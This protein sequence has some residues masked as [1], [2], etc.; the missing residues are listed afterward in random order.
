MNH[1]SM[2]GL[3]APRAQDQQPEAPKGQGPSFL[4][5]KGY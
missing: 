3:Q 5:A 2:M 4:G 1:E